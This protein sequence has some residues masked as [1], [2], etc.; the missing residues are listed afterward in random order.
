MNKSSK[1]T[2]Q[3]NREKRHYRTASAYERMMKRVDIP[4]D[5]SK[6]WLWTGPVNNAGYGMIRGNDGVPKMM[7][8]HRVAG[9]EKGLDSSR[10]IQHT[11][12]TKNCVNPAHLVEGDS[13]SR[14][15]RIV[16]KYG[17]NFNKPKDPYMTCLHCERTDHVVWF[18]RKHKDCYPGMLNKYRTYLK[19][20]V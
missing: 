15:D 12:L 19:N 2:N 6:C 7:T 16:A 1:K 3:S 18:S 13:K 9:I 20:K 17:A 4:K 14:H 5:K 11:C 8:V 10:E